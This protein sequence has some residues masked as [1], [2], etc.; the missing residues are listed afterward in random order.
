[1]EAGPQEVVESRMFELVVRQ[2]LQILIIIG[3]GKD[4]K[5]ARLMV[6]RGG[7]NTKGPGY[8]KDFLWGY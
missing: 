1:M 8:G 4:Q 7:E 3:L 5:R 6:E 2:G